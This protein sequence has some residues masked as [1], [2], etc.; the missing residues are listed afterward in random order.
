MQQ[1]VTTTDGYL[2]TTQRVLIF[3]GIVIAL[4]NLADGQSFYSTGA[5]L[6]AISVGAG[7][8][9]LGVAPAYQ[10]LR[11]LVLKTIPRLVLR[12]VAVLSVWVLI[13]AI[14]LTGLELYVRSTHGYIVWSLPLKK[15][16]STFSELYRVYIW[17]RT[18]YNQNRS[19]FANWPIPLEFF[20][21]PSPVPAYELRPNEK[22]TMK[23]G[24]LLPAGPGDPV[25]W[26][27]NS[28][29]LR[30]PEFSVKKPHGVIRI[31]CI[32]A[33]TTAGMQGDNETYP[34]YLQQELNRR[35][36]GEQ[37]E[38]INAGFYGLSL[39]DFPAI[40]RN[41]VLPLQ[42]DIVLFYEAN[43]SINFQDF[44]TDLP[45]PFWSCWLDN[46]PFW[47]RWLYGHS[48]VFST[49]ADKAGWN[50][51]VPPPMAHT[52]DW[53]TVTASETNYHQELAAFAREIQSHG[54]Q[55]VLSSFIN[56]AYDGLNITYNDSPGVFDSVYKLLY[57]LT[58]GEIG[59]VYDRINKQSAAVARE[60]HTPYADVA[61]DFP[62]GM[63]N[64]DYDN[65]HL[66]P[67]GNKILAGRFA[68]FL[69][70]QVLPDITKDF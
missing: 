44:V 35:F 38:V 28:W 15:Q 48:A 8:A 59:N 5:Q 16:E 23:A 12:I 17:N 31:I 51:V 69:A 22:R 10:P 43:N 27:S 21:S 1:N 9:L 58:P 46:Y 14:S 45:C 56:A 53:T 61:A 19:F 47:Y 42:P 32:G 57:P 40:F 68:E 37:I 3:L 34:Y 24:Q 6:A 29:G 63:E 2:K 54:I 49:I 52:F 60:L 39:D 41:K 18:F 70:K 62:H 26:S 50:N 25:Y 67:A 20:D 65:Y 30:G 7:I 11:R 13:L 55:V 33:S 4:L 66:S 64:F 36:P